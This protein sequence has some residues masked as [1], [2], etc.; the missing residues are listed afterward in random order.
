MNKLLFI[1]YNVILILKIH[2]RLQKYFIYLFKLKIKL[3][4]YFYNLISIIKYKSIMNIIIYNIDLKRNK[5]LLYCTI[6][7]FKDIYSFRIIT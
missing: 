7:N 3:I 6:I 1:F 5:D 4:Y 2:F